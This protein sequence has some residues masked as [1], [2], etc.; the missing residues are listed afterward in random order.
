MTPTFGMTSPVP[1]RLL[2]QAGATLSQVKG[3]AQP[4]EDSDIQ[5]DDVVGLIVGFQTI[6]RALLERAPQ[7]RVV[8]KHGSGVDN[9]DI[10]AATD[11]GVVVTNA[12]GCNSMAV[13]EFTLGVMLAVGRRIPYQD[14]GVRGGQWAIHVGVE[15][16]GAVLGIIGMGR[17]GRLV[18]ARARAFDMRVVYT[19][20]APIADLGDLDAECEFR[21]L[22]AL[23]EESDFVTIHAPLMPSTTHLI[24]AD[25]LQRMKPT[26]FLV[27]AAR[28]EI[29]D[30]E[31][32]EEA[33]ASGWIAGAALDVFSQEPLRRG[34]LIAQR[35]RT[36]LTPHTAG[37]TTQ[38]LAATSILTAENVVDALQG[39]WPR[40]ALNQPAAWPR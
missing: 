32:L 39:R 3:A 37:Y 35:E 24:N 9:I 29:V 17:V 34:D 8:A 11:S 10:A 26:A 6:D 15:L 21:E 16:A 1:A 18:A 2:H 22:P 23:L 31:A 27:N 12:P 33:L 13:A 28:G 14:A 19:D 20:S 4:G 7:L 25:A 38:S 5:L 30:E 36:V 40:N